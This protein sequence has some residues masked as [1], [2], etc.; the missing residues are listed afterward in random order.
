MKHYGFTLAEVLITLGIIGIVAAM[1]IPTLLSKYREKEI[2]T[3]LRRTQSIIAQAIRMAEDEYGTPEEWELT[4]G[5]WN[6]A[7]AEKIAEII[8]P[9]LKII[10]DCGVN[11]NSGKC[12]SNKTYK[13]LKGTTYRNFASDTGLYKVTLFDGTSI[14][15]GYYANRQLDFFIDINGKYPPNVVGKDMFAITYIFN[16]GL[17]PDGHPTEDDTPWQTNCNL[18]STGWGCAYYILQYNN[19]NYLHNK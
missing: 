19:M 12:F 16:E 1:T 11:D 15:W 4:N 10:L 13:Y 17:V 18:N 8:K 7:S 9:N 3:K 2:V 14:C 5:N 6:S